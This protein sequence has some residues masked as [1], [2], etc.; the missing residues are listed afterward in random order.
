M[1]LHTDYIGKPTSRVDGP[2]KVTGAAKYAAEFNVPNLL[3]GYVVS[4]PI[5]KGKILKIN[6]APVLALPPPP[7][8]SK[9][10]M[11]PQRPG[12][13]YCCSACCCC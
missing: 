5:T 3:Y 7:P 11:E 13:P 2:A 4:S 12:L 1:S 10:P 9:R 8:L 6:A